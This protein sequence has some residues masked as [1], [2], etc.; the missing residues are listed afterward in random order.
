MNFK[1]KAVSGRELSEERVRSRFL[2][3]RALA[4][5]FLVVF[6]AGNLLQEQMTANS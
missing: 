6:P 2:A 3:K 4:F 1:L 5:A